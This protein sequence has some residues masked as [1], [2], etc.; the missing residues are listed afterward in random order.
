MPTAFKWTSEE[1]QDMVT[2][3]QQDE[4]AHSIAKRYGT[5]HQVILPLLVKQ[6]IVL[7]TS[8]EARK[9]QTCDELYFQVIDTEEKAYW[10]GFLTADGCVTKG[11]KSGE[12]PRITIH[13]A[14]QDYGHLIKFKQALQATQMVS[15]SGQGCSFT[16]FSSEMA[17]DLATHGILPNKTFSTKPVQVSS[18]LERHY[19]RGVID[20]DGTFAK[21]GRSLAL[22]GDYDVVLAFQAFVLSHC[23]E[24]RAT[25]RKTENIFVFHIGK[26]ATLCIL[27]LLY[28]ES[29]VYLDRKYERA[30]QMVEAM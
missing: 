21:N 3:Y 13:L 9:K 17:A 5:S 14:K 11:K 24:V 15:T 20:G 19:W 25:V 28:G 2:S 8:K 12:S 4:S 7:R 30:K 22:V 29:I 23:P 6:G 10:M 16:I 27:Q 1:L 26:Q 18:E